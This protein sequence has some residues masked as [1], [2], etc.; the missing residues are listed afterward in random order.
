MSNRWDTLS[1]CLSNGKSRFAATLAAGL[2]AVTV[3]GFTSTTAAAATTA[4]VPA[5]VRLGHTPRLPA[6]AAVVSPLP[7]ATT[8]SVN[9]VLQPRNP[10]ALTAYA[11]AVSTPGTDLYRHYLSVRQFA[12]RFGPTP[13]TIRSVDR[14]L[15]NVGLHPGIASTNGLSITV[16]A[17]AGQLSAAFSTG[18]ERYR[19]S[20]G[21]IAYANT[22][23]PQI[24]GAVAPFV[25]TVVGLDDLSLAQPA[26]QQS[27]AGG[28]HAAEEP[29]VATGGPQPCAKAVTDASD[30]DSLTTD[31]V[32]AAYGF[33]NL[34][35]QGDLGSGQ[36]V[37]LYELQGYGSK[38]I[39]TY[40]TCYGTSTSVATVLVDGGPL[41]NSGVGEADIDIE[42]VLSLAP[43]TH[44][45][46]YEGPNSA[47]GVY[48]TYNSIVTQDK[49]KVV[50][51]SWGL[52]E[53]SE[54]S[55]AAQA[56]NT[57][58]E[59]AATQ[60]QTLVAA[61]G[62]QGSED[63]LGSDYSDDTL[64]VDDPSSQPF[65]T[66][67]GGTSWSGSVTAPSES[68][69]NDG[70]CDCFGASG[71]GI[72]A[73]WT[74]PSY[75][76]SSHGIG[77]TNSG[78]SG[79]PCDAATGAYC[80]ETPDVSALAGQYPYLSYVSGAWGD[81]GGTSFAAPLWAS[82]IALSNA[83]ST[84]SG[85][86]IGFAN[87]IL[88]E[89]EA[90]DPTA[91]NDITVGNNDLTGENDGA[92]P[93]LVGYDM[94]SGL[95]TPNGATLPAALCSAFAPVFTSL[96]STTFSEN[97]ASTFAVTATGY[98][99]ITFTESGAL[100]SGVTLASNGTLSGTPSFGTAGSYPVTI[101]ATDVHAN[102][103]TQAFTLKVSASAPVFKSIDST[104]FAENS[105]SSFSVTA[106][107]DAP[108][109]FTES[110]AL[111]SGVTLA[112]NGTLSGTPSF[113][114]AGSYPITITATDV[115]ANSSTQAFTLT[116][117]ASV[118]V[119]TSG[120]S[121]TFMALQAGTFSVA[122]NGDA[123][124]G[125]TETGSLPSG[126]T[127]AS[128]GTLSGTPALGT[129][130]SYPITITATDVHANTSTQA[131]TLTVNNT[132]PTTSVLVPSNGAGVH[133]NSV[134]L[135]ASATASAGVG[136][137]KVQFVITGGSYNQSVIGTA[138]ATEYGYILQWST[139][140]VPG[141]TYR[142]Q[143]L[144]T[145][146]AGNTTYS[147]P[148]SVTVD[149]TPPTTAV[150]VPSTGAKLGG[151][152]AILD[153]SA[154]ASYGVGISKVQFVITG[155]SYNQSVIGTA[156]PTEYGYI[157]QWNTTAVPGGTY[158]LQSLATDGAGNTTYSSGISVTVDN[159]PPTT[160]VTV[161]ANGA[162]LVRSASTSL[163]A[164]ASAS[165]G[166]GISSVKFVLTGGTYNQ[167]VIGTATSTGNGWVYT[168]NDTAVPKD[169][170]TLQSLATDG[171]GNTAYSERITVVIKK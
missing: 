142:L 2:I 20:G 161:P 25:Q 130:G 99:P 37:D 155:G 97:S 135:D 165:F 53:A 77:V 39:S 66:A 117:T 70:P 83:S 44:I 98:T 86:D 107:G 103:S 45:L 129:V 133:G 153:A 59:E 128:N 75:Q 3:S 170:Y 148:I 132:P 72:S 154:A 156:V 13:S 93:A 147:S 104:T 11:Q 127:L 52:C 9:V 19:V 76:S 96:G 137:S 10:S 51:T 134:I 16:R 168:W 73:L 120:T 23:P 157:L 18:F 42:Q 119:F 6:D 5:R 60:G 38:D 159:T 36:T 55:S 123:P 160:A 65:V 79:T 114:T 95:G 105:V 110:G 84:C 62:D 61:S 34:Y 88:Y 67:A 111:P 158:T 145:D 1:G 47:T 167:T 81:W 140:A 35:K 152:S 91:F 122:A 21:R 94:A 151:T 43:E 31:E 164:T 17:T 87:P 112:S 92:Y 89:V 58:F 136:I 63:C 24:S 4:N 82:L 102:S 121:T 125:F 166:V 15:G 56:E 141:G 126:V 163:E 78:S 41:A 27:P 131:F 113:G 143:S 30:D 26:S 106:T 150:L 57:V 68:V 115:H 64:A 90:S 138:V 48:D 29:H 54:G 33:S 40:Q 124:I 14:A 139:T 8:L 162:K 169:T 7:E 69:W 46:V 149:N 12:D 146:G 171:A 116:V 118:P 28:S 22:A 49:A 100:P 101:T 50:S 144:A 74:M 109:T 80:R 71:G 32:A 85:K 108:I